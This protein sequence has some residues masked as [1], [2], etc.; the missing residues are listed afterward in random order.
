MTPPP[1]LAIVG[2]TGVG[3]SEVALAI[4]RKTPCEIVVVDSMQVYRGMDM[5]TGKPD[6][7]ARESA[8]HHGIDLVDPE[9]EFDVAQY[10]QAVRPLLG[11]IERRGRLPLLVGG[12]G[13]YL[14]A[15]L[16]G[17]CEAPGKDAVLRYQLLE[18]GSREGTAPLYAKLRD[19]DP[20]AAVKIH[21]NDLRRIVRALEVF[22][23]TGRPLS[24]WQGETQKP[25]EERQA[26][27]IGLT[28]DRQVL[29]QRIERRIDGWL[30]SGWLEEARNLHRRNLSRTARLALGYLELFAF[31]EGEANWET[32]VRLI[33]QNT[34]HYAKRQWAWFKQDRRIEWVSLDEQASENLAG[35]LAARF[36]NRIAHTAV[37]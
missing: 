27:L 26:V 7:A 30:L 2:P 9:Q 33:K 25:F 34:R 10:V 24:Q 21:P 22:W 37:R 11:E 31:L 19:F 28:C 20:T 29:Y 4:A 14:R 36:R 5:G 17:L 12:S 1:F 6:S 18:Q 35:M 16:D 32:T 8:P 13:L 3:K 15:L 23:V